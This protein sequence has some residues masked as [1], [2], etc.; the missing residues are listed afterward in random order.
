[1]AHSFCKIYIHA[2]F[3]TKDRTRWL[4]DTVRA[5]VHAYIASVARTEGCPFVVVGGA[6]DHVHILMDIGKNV[7]PVDLIAKI[8]TTSSS[9]VKT[10]GADYRNFY[11]QG[12][13]GM[14]SVAPTRVADVSS[15]IE[16]QMEHHR[17]Q[18]FRDEFLAFLSRYEIEYDERYIW[19]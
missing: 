11:W 17:K 14:F 6:E 18:T 12:G 15:Y 9:F 5:R 8:K 2:I 4:D 10:L 13:Y 1:M 19:T 3:S 7:K 16:R